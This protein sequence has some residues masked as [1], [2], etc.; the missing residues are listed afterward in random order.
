MKRFVLGFVV[1][2]VLVMV[3]VMVLGMEDMMVLPMCQTRYCRL[4]TF[5]LTK[6]D[7]TSNIQDNPSHPVFLL[8]Y[9]SIPVPPLL[10][11]VAAKFGGNVG[12]CGY[13]FVYGN[14]YGAGYC[15]R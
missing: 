10:C 1:G 5:H 13:G 9:Y 3:L 14:G 12:Y 7:M 6:S 15:T 8:T 4:S 2:M 11:R